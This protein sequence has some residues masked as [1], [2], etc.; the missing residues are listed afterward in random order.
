MRLHNSRLAV[1]RC[2]T[3]S[4]AMRVCVL[5]CNAMVHVV[6]VM[7][8]RDTVELLERICDLAHG[9]CQTR[10]QWDTLGFC[11]T[12]IHALTLFD[13]PEVRCLDTTAL[14]GNHWWLHVAKK[15]PLRCTEERMCFHIGGSCSGTEA[16]KLILSQKFANKGFAEALTMLARTRCDGGNAYFDTDGYPE[17][18]GNGTSSRRI[19]AK[20]ALRFL[21]LKGVVPYNIS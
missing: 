2:T 11:S 16:A 5:G 15:C 6:A 4:L 9:C 18:S 1:I 7:V 8:E 12:N 21:P 17:P 20:V 10:I 3:S 13:I 19:L 14:V